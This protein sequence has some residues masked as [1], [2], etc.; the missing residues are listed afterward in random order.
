MDDMKRV[1][2]RLEAIEQSLKPKRESW[3]AKQFTNIR[4]HTDKPTTFIAATPLVFGGVLPAV[5]SM[6]A[7]CP[8]LK[9][10]VDVMFIAFI[11]T[12][13]SIPLLIIALVGLKAEWRGL[14]LATAGQF[15]AV[16]VG[17]GSIAGSNWRLVV[18]Y[19]LML[20]VAAYVARLGVKGKSLRTIDRRT[21]ARL[22]PLS[23]I[24]IIAIIG[25][26]WVFSSVGDGPHP[27]DIPA[28][29][30]N[31]PRLDIVDS[32]AERIHQRRSSEVLRLAIA[33][34]TA[35]GVDRYPDV[36]SAKLIADIQNLQTAAN[37]T[38]RSA[39]DTADTIPVDMAGAVSA[40]GPDIIQAGASARPLDSQ[41]KAASQ[42]K[43]DTAHAT[44]ASIADRS[45][46][47]RR[48]VA[49]LATYDAQASML[50]AAIN[51]RVQRE[52]AAVLE[53]ERH[54]GRF[55]LWACVACAF[56]GILVVNFADLTIGRP[57]AGTAGI[58]GREA[59]NEQ[60]TS[61]YILSM[62]LCL[63]FAA[64]SLG[65]VDPER[66]DV[67][68]A[69]GAFTVAPWFLPAAIV[70]YT[71]PHTHDAAQGM[72]QLEAPPALPVEARSEIDTASF[73]VTVAQ[74]V[75]RDSTVQGLR[76][77]LKTHGD[78]IHALQIGV[79]SLAGK[80]GVRTGTRP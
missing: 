8:R 56:C 31:I 60:L 61:Y 27:R 12:F 47:V 54:I 68:D 40:F 23:A 4:G 26:G 41:L 66:V 63:I 3:L 73:A 42:E 5:L 37:A 14:V 29:F 75:T 79:D 58:R 21:T 36:D 34:A 78:A 11:A 65:P 25:A 18:S 2:A 45:R 32:G 48:Y 67:H 69:F 59:T 10:Y 19:L 57:R 77:G 24:A 44:N 80:L 76:K 1:E 53:K 52:M 9:P 72:P 49:A 30:Q 20:L 64:A 38:E 6:V 22:A 39:G 15:A 43:L 62:G 17:A 50:H 13:L 71:A 33:A 51:T 16:F 7:I 55:T 28:I 70:D 74:R 46:A 35:A